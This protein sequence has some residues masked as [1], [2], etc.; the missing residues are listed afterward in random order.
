LDALS[1]FKE[2]MMRTRNIHAVSSNRCL[3]G[4]L[5]F[6]LALSCVASASAASVKVEDATSKDLVRYL[7]DEQWKARLGSLVE[8]ES[9]GL[10]QAVDKVV[11]LAK[12]DAHYKVR[13]QALRV[14]EGMESSWLVPT[15]EHVV[16]EDA[17]VANREEALK[18]IEK[19][20]EGSRSAMVLGTV[21]ASDSD[22]DMREHAAR[23]IREKQWSGAEKQLGRA[24]LRDGDAGVRRECRRALA[25]VGG[26][27]SRSVLHRVLR[28]EPNKK[29]RLEVAELLEDAPLPTDRDPL[30]KALDDPYK[31][32]AIAAARGL[33]RLG[34][35]S[36]AAILRKKAL[37]NSDRAVS[38]AFSEAATALGD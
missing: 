28:D 31:K 21:L 38:A 29:Y 18:L 19:L 9:R 4:L 8:I 10:I 23:V 35:K 36:V 11:E 26:G 16:S 25:V 2:I 1:A 34:D 17:V 33:A 30:V 32:I 27:E 37:E 6:I 22:A 3:T 20:G 7:D 5:S 13:L 15:A 12:A 24:A 14:L